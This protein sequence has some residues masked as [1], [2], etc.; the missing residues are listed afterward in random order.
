MCFNPVKSEACAEIAIIVN[1]GVDLQKSVCIKISISDHNSPSI[2]S[3]EVKV[4]CDYNSLF[5]LS[6][7]VEVSY[8]HNS[9]YILSYEVKVS[10]DYNSLYNIYIII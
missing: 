7:E 4:P 5:I 1:V 9:P 10:C 3:Y 2:L 6:Y 8:D